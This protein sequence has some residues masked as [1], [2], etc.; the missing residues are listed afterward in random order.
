M[1]GSVPAVQ[2]QVRLQLHHLDEEICTTTYAFRD[3]LEAGSHN[4]STEQDARKSLPDP[5]AQPEWGRAYSR[6]PNPTMQYLR[7]D[8]T[9]SRYRHGHYSDMCHAVPSRPQ[10]QPR[11]GRSVGVKKNQ[12][13]CVGR[14]PPPTRGSVVHDDIERVVNG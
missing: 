10:L 7:R 5:H 8:S 11:V 13:E 14:P 9:L 2:V 6:R 1:H 4:Y 12:R 3:R